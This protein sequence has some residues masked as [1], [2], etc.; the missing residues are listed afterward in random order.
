MQKEL[1]VFEYN[2]FHF[3]ILC[4][5]IYLTYNIENVFLVV[6]DQPMLCC[7]TDPTFVFILVT[8]KSGNITVDIFYV[9]IL[10][11]YNYHACS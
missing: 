8:L 11:C 10:T 7:Q 9:K 1:S 5:W 4:V 6:K 3:V 2:N